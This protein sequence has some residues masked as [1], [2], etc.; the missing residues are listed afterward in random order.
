MTGVEWVGGVALA[1]GRRDLLRPVAGSDGP[2]EL[3]ERCY[4]PERRGYVQ[5]ELVVTPAEVLH[6]GVAGGDHC[7][8]GEAFQPAHRPQPNLEPAVIRFDPVVGVSLGDMPR[9]R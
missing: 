3:G 4:E 2:S 5:R 8:G 1:A 7:G 6:E 9:R